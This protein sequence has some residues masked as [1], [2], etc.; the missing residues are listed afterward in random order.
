SK[1]AAEEAAELP[2]LRRMLRQILTA[3][4]V[5]PGS[6]DYKEL[7]AVFNALP[8]SELLAST[9]PEI[10]ADLRQILAAVRSD[11]IVVS[12]RGQPGNGRVAALVVLP[13]GR[14]SSEARQRIGGLLQERLGGELLDDHLTFVD[15]DRALL[16]F[17]LTGGGMTAATPS[18]A[19]LR[20]AVAA[21][22]RTWDERLREALVAQHGESEGARLVARD[23]GALPDACKA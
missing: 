21:M 11:E 1:A 17:T 12:L 10:R 14:F 19:E 9:P 15:G 16:H 8:K 7:V 23:A 5:V 22:V 20:D 2:I 6:H 13:P 3:E 4:Q 18:T